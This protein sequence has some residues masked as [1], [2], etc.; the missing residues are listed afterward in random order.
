MIGLLRDHKKKIM[1]GIRWTNEF[2]IFKLN[3]HIE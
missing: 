3:N 2:F 1:I